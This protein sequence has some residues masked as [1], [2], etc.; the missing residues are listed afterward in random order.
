MKININTFCVFP[1]SLWLFSPA[2]AGTT[3]IYSPSGLAPN[4]APDLAPPVAPPPGAPAASPQSLDF[5]PVGTPLP[6]SSS[7]GP[8]NRSPNSP[9]ILQET[10]VKDI[11]PN[12]PQS[13][14]VESF[15]QL[16]KTLPEI[17]PNNSQATTPKSAPSG[18]SNSLPANFGR[19]LWHIL[20]NAGVPMNANHDSDLE[21]SIVK[22]V[23]WPFT[24]PST[25]AVSHNGAVKA[26]GNLE[27][28]Q[29]NENQGAPQKIPQS[30][31]EGIEVPPNNENQNTHY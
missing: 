24:K 2:F 9:D 10:I 22:G 14:S 13:S 8:T 29:F 11:W 12:Q 4:N 18:K 30:E 15:F 31:L 19:L 7:I 17:V 1:L 3:Q 23:D 6:N 16:T 28:L 20:D 25:T 21:P 27:R 26:P 5:M